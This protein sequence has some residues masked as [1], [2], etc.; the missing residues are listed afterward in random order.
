MM[1]FSQYDFKKVKEEDKIMFMQAED[2]NKLEW[3]NNRS[4]WNK[5]FHPFATMP[6]KYYVEASKVKTNKKE[7]VD[8]LDPLLITITAIAIIVCVGL[9]L[10]FGLKSKGLL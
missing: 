7:L 8:I 10:Y 5:L 1:D 2:M 9:Y 6:K 3:F 4:F